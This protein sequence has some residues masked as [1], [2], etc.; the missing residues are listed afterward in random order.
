MGSDSKWEKIDF[1]PILPAR[2]LQSS[3]HELTQFLL[4][5]HSIWLIYVLR[6][7]TSMASSDKSDFFKEFIGAP[8]VRDS[9]SPIPEELHAGL[10]SKRDL[11]YKLFSDIACGLPGAAGGAV[12]ALE[13]MISTRAWFLSHTARTVEIIALQHASTFITWADWFCKAIVPPRLMMHPAFTSR[14]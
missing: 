13:G 2:R 4:I 11:M 6:K 1:R 7:I 8:S 5:R 3:F 10:A 12:T 14:R 9:P